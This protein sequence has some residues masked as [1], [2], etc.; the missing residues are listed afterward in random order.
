MQSLRSTV[1]HVGEV[2]VRRAKVSGEF[3]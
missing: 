1:R 3:V 2:R